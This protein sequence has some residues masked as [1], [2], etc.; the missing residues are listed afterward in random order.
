[1]PIR[2]VSL[3][4]IPIRMVG[5]V[6]LQSGWLACM[7]RMPIRVVCLVRMQIR[8]A[9]FVRMVFLDMILVMDWIVDLFRMVG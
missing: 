7:N 3:V 2:M 4:R 5:L 8:M 6:R 9:G 1:M